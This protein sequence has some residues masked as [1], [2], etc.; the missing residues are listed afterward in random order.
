MNQDLNS[1]LFS[2]LKGLGYTLAMYDRDGKGPISEPRLAEW[3]YA[4]NDKDPLLNITVRLP[5]KNPS[6]FDQIIVYKSSNASEE[7]Q[8][9]IERIKTCGLTFGYTTSYRQFGHS[10]EPKDLAFIP[11]ARKEFFSQ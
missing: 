8:K 5:V 4:T 9:I 11:K 7:I 6:P 10:I 1:T 2:V 3:M